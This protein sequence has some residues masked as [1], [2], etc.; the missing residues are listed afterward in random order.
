MAESGA[1]IH[2]DTESHQGASILRVRGV[3]DDTTYRKLRDTIIKSALAE[4]SVVLVD[5]DDLAVPSGSAYSVFTSAR[6][7]VS[8]WPDVPILLVCTRPQ[9]QCEIARGGAGRHVPVHSS[10]GAALGAVGD[11]S[12]G[13]RRRARAQLPAEAASVGLARLSITDWLTAWDQEDLTAIAGTVATIFVENVLAHTKSAPLLI[14]ESYRDSVTVAVEDGS[15]VP[16]ALHEDADHGAEIV[17]GLGIVAALCRAWGS[18]PTS[19]G[20][21]VWGSV[22]RESAMR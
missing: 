4:P 8:I 18:T 19:T 10:V 12:S 9:R 11:L 2:I 17:S 16:A 5:I 1:P 6:W 7:Y 20:K 22:G 14:V 15:R 21:T 13:G 3:L